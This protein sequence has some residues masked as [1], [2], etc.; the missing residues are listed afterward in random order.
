MQGKS[1]YSS[2]VH[3]V[4]AP[5]ATLVPCVIWEWMKDDGEYSPYDPE[6]SEAIEGAYAANSPQHQVRTGYTISFAYMIQTRV[7]TGESK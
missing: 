5:M 6:S 2:T 3:A 4:A 7:S 1:P